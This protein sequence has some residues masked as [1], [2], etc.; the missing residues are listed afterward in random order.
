[1][2]T[3]RR[4][5]L[6]RSVSMLG[7][8]MV[9]LVC[10]V[11]IIGMFAVIAVPR[12]SSSIALHR[13]E[14]AARRIVVDLALAQRQAKSANVAQTVS[15]NPALDNYALLGMPHPDYP[16][17]EYGTSLQEEPYGATIVSAD[18]G[19]DLNII[20]DVFGVPDSGGSVVISVGPRVRTIVVDAETGKATVQ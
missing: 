20:F 4:Q 9:E 7:F 8:T 15:F 12:F 17:R 16:A 2:K 11:V 14:S 1:M 13:V 3:T 5:T 10:V 6:S 18:F 19:G